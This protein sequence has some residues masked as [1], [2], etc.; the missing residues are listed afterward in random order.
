M[1]TSITDTAVGAALSGLALRQKVIANNVANINTPGFLAGTV[2]FEGALSQA[3]ADG[4]SPAVTPTMARSLEPTQLNGN[5]VNLDKETV[6]SIDTQLRYQLMIRALD[7]SFTRLG[8]A[9]SG[10]A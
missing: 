2:Q 10:N 7:D 5:N 8:T 4:S 6:S 1:F 3:L 9:I